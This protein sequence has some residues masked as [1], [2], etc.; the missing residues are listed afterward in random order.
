M[1]LWQLACSLRLACILGARGTR[2][3]AVAHANRKHDERRARGVGLVQLE[4]EVAVALGEA[5]AEGLGI[6]EAQR[7]DADARG[8]RGVCRF[9]RVD[10]LV[11]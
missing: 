2:V 5:A 7:P 10:H 11:T 3:V 6:A 4:A 9:D 1:S 8:D